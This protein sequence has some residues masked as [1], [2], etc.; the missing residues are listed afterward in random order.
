VRVRKYHYEHPKIN[1]ELVVNT[2][3]DEVFPHCHKHGYKVVVIDND[4]K[5]HCMALVKAGEEEGIQIYPGSGK[6]CWVNSELFD[7][8]SFRTVIRGLGRMLKGST[9]L[10]ATNV[11]L[12]KLSLP[13]VTKMLSW[14]LSDGK[15][16]PINVAQ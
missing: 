11:C 2:F 15:Q 12:L 13:T 3:Q 9:L 8:G 5:F 6:R 1:A 10:E 7:F 14:M 4:S 16:M